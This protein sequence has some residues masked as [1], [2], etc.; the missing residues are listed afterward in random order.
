MESKWTMEELSDRLNEIENLLYNKEGVIDKI[1]NL[2]YK[3]NS[4]CE[5]ITILENK[6]E[7]DKYSMI[8]EASDDS[9]S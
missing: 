4:I 5:K 3:V 1:E 6:I 9:E 8:A 7:L 2:L